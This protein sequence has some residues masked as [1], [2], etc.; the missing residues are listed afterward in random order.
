[1]STPGHRQ[2]EETMGKVVRF[3]D[4]RRRFLKERAA[5]CSQCGQ[6]LKTVATEPTKSLGWKIVE[7]FWSLVVLSIVLAVLFL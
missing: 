2:M 7:G 3:P 4:S 6:P 1:M 5:Y